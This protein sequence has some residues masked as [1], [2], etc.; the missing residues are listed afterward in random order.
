VLSTAIVVAQTPVTPP[1][2]KYSPSQDVELGREAAAEARRTLP[3]LRDEVVTSFLDDVGNRLVNGIPANLRHPEFRYSFEAVNVRDINAFALPG[4]PMFVNRGMMEAARNEGEVAGVMAHELSH[5]VLRHGTAQAGKATPYQIG[6][7]AGAILGAIVGGT[8]G[9]VIA[10]GTQFGLGTMFLKYGR[11]YERQADLLGA[12]I[13]ARVGYE[14]RD[15]ANMFKTIEQK[16]G[17][18]GPEWMSSHPNPGNRYDAIIK[19]SSSLRVENPVRDTQNFQRAVSRL[20]SMQRAPTTEEVMRNPRNTRN[21]GGTTPRGTRGR[22]ATRVEPPSPRFRD[23]NEGDLFRIS[24]PVNWEELAR[25]NTVT[26]AP[27]GAYDGGV[28]THGVE[29]GVTRNE[30]HDLQQATEELIDSLRGSNPRL[31]EVSR[32]A[33]VTMS[34]RRGLQTT[35]TNVS[36]ATGRDERIQLVTVPMNDGNMFYAIAVAPEDEAADYRSTFQR[37]F[38]S[39]RITQ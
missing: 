22:I 9:S 11:A 17:S 15:M 8:T 2:N 10:Q 37:V 5:V 6:T 12:Q 34:G 16:S 7:I 39:I 18:G 13:M 33:R 28:F 29:L 19:E 27:D 32:P 14:P 1:D 31:R 26:F 23:Y 30:T 3:L 20:R 21:E 25:S 38:G 24:V 36:D 35:L 4:G